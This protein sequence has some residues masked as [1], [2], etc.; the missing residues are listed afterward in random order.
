MLWKTERAVAEALPDAP[1]APEGLGWTP[2]DELYPTPGEV[3]CDVAA[4]LAATSAL[5]LIVPLLL[6]ALGL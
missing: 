2:S 6:D 5:A 3:I 4:T 1:S